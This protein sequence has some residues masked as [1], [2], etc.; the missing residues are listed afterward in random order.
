M[1]I[2]ER[3]APELLRGEKILW[4]GKPGTKLLSWWELLLVP[5]ALMVLAPPILIAQAP[6][7][8]HG[9]PPPV[10][11]IVVLFVFFGSFG[12]WLIP[13]HFVIKARRL[14]KTFYAVTNFRVLV[15]LE[16]RRS[17]LQA[18]FIQQLPLVVRIL[19]RNGIGTVRFGL[20]S[21]PYAQPPFEG[22]PFAAAMHAAQAPAF[23][24]I[25]DAEKVY[26]LVSELQ[27]AAIGG[28]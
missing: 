8:A 5:F 25:A 15:L 23:V 21:G 24:D 12:L 14:R 9:Q 7:P 17:T 10:A 6:P 26:K 13:G 11:L 16:L 3:F 27:H 4:A 2:E 28:S 20:G 1:S 22:A 18:A 19:R